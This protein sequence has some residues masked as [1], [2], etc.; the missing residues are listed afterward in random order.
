PFQFTGR[1]PVAAGLYNYR[2]RFYS[3]TAGRFVSEDPIGF[4]GSIPNLYAY[5]ENSPSDQIDPFGLASNQ[6]YVSV[7]LTAPAGFGAAGFLFP[8]FFATGSSGFAITST[9]QVYFQV[10]GGGLVGVGIYAG[11]GI[12]VGGGVASFSPGSSCAFLTPAPATTG[13]QF[14][15]NAGAGPS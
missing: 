1:V 14:Q 6:G 3:P 11:A 9:G 15:T 12:Q 13:W 5:A 2:A 10:Q 8:A 7:S 4:A